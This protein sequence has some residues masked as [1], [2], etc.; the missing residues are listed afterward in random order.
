V[1]QCDG[2]RVNKNK[3]LGRGTVQQPLLP[4]TLSRPPLAL[5]L[6]LSNINRTEVLA[7][8]MLGISAAERHVF[9]HLIRR[10]HDIRIGTK[11]CL[12]QAMP[13]FIFRRFYGVRSVCRFIA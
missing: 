8:V 3:D 1:D 12:V 10:L 4:E 9:T 2:V 5:S 6:K 13:R 7:N 11:P